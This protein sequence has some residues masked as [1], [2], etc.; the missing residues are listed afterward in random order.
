M[1]WLATMGRLH[2]MDRLYRFGV[3]QNSTCVLC[4]SFEESH[5]HL[6]FECDFAKVIWQS[7]SSMVPIRWPSLSWGV[8]LRWAVIKL[9]R[10]DDPF[11]AVA[12]IA[13]AASVYFIW[14]ERNRRVF[15][16]CS[17]STDGV[18]EEIVETIRCRLI[19]LGSSCLFPDSIKQ[20]WNLD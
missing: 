14:Y 15:D 13:L 7:I 3:V 19:F 10:I 11:S 6:F 9:R 17:I 5:D 16:N 8:F 4:S 1:L 2:T 18:I 20:I 12:R